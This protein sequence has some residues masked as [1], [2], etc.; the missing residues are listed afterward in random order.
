MARRTG[1]RGPFV[2]VLPARIKR[3]TEN[4][5]PILPAGDTRKSRLRTITLTI[6][7][8]D[9]SQIGVRVGA[10]KGLIL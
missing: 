10:Q 5:D 4:L 7:P 6:E 3:D 9:R 1:D 2:L 8:R